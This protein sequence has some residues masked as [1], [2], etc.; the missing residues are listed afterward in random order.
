MQWQRTTQWTER[1][2]INEK[3][4][5]GCRNTRSGAT[6]TGNIRYTI[7]VNDTQS[8]VDTVKYSLVGPSPA[9]TDNLVFTE[10]SAPWDVSDDFNPFNTATL[11]DGSYQF[12]VVAT[13]VAGNATTANQS[14]TLDNFTDPT[15][16]TTPTIALSADDTTPEIGQFVV[17]TIQEIGRASCRERVSSPV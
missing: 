4:P 17:F 9:T 14:V 1:N 5:S 12:R 11:A 13:D 10:T 15:P 2:P 8:G 3:A 7:A 16:P 6:I